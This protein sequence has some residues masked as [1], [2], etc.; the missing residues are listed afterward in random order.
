MSSNSDA[1]QKT[2][3][4]PRSDQ[5][6]RRDEPKM[7]RAYQRTNDQDHHPMIIK[8]PKK[9]DVQHTIPHLK[10]AAWLL[11]NYTAH[12]CRSYLPKEGSK[13]SS[14]DNDDEDSESDKVLNFV[15][16]TGWLTHRGTFFSAMEIEESRTDTVVRYISKFVNTEA[17]GAQLQI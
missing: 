3:T 1:Q 7:R 16:V 15:S 9:N 5:G 2:P 10:S 12:K 11:R 4:K 8:K 13:T 17:P 14:E 6:K